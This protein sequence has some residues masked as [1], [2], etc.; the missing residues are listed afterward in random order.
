[1]ILSQPFQVEEPSFQASD[2]APPAL[3]KQD[4]SEVA[5]GGVANQS[6]TKIAPFDVIKGLFPALVEQYGVPGKDQEGEDDVQASPG[7]DHALEESGGPSVIIHSSVPEE[8]DEDEHDNE[9]LSYARTYP[10][11]RRM[12]VYAGFFKRNDPSKEDLGTGLR[13]ILSRSSSSSSDDDLPSIPPRAL[14]GQQLPGS[15]EYLGNNLEDLEAKSALDLYQTK[16]VAE[17]VRRE[18]A[19]LMQV[20]LGQAPCDPT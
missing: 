19:S 17:L 16:K 13:S 11:E 7:G 5:S 18:Q 9:E 3:S 8:K 14:Q 12:A 4:S 6:P 15:L 20:P 1:V 10:E 2:Q